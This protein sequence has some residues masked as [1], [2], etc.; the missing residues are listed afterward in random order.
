MEASYPDRAT[1]ALPFY[2]TLQIE[3]LVLAHSCAA[4]NE[5]AWARFLAQ[6][7]LML[8]SAARTLCGEELAAR[9]LVTL[10]LGK[11]FGVQVDTAG[12]RRSKLALYTGRGSLGA[13]LRA[14]LAQACIDQH[15]L[16]RRFV[17]LDEALPFLTSGRTAADAN[18][19]VDPRVGPA[20]ELGIRKLAPECRLVLKAHYLDQMTLAEIAK[21]IGTHES[22]V[23]RRL[24]KVT[25]RLRRSI[26]QSLV[27]QGM[28]ISAAHQALT[29]DFRYV[30]ADIEGALLRVV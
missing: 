2:D 11:L 20:V 10:L 17:S 29:S 18:T 30:S 22:T 4:G 8:H 14:T 19:H 26:L 1:R 3:D 16:R 27:G 5:A 9:E 7:N 24:A 25:K 13:W 15:R 6:Y 21:L 28:S 12:K 23:S